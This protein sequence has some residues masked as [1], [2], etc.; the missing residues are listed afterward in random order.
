MW[1]SPRKQTEC[2]WEVSASSQ[3]LPETQLLKIILTNVLK[4]K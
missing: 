3:I 1:T 4:G 2:I